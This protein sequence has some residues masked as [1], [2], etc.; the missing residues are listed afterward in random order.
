[1]IRGN[2]SSSMYVGTDSFNKWIDEIINGKWAKGKKRRVPKTKKLQYYSNGGSKSTDNEDYLAG[3]SWFTEGE[4]SKTPKTSEGEEPPK[5]PVMAYSAIINKALEAL[6]EI[7]PDITEEIESHFPP[8]SERDDNIEVKKAIAEALNLTPGNVGLVVQQSGK[9][10]IFR[11]KVPFTESVQISSVIL[12][13]KDTAGTYNFEITV[14]DI[15]YKASLDSDFNLV[16]TP[17]ETVS[18]TPLKAVAQPIVK[19]IPDN[20]ETWKNL[21]KKIPAQQTRIPFVAQFNAFLK[22]GD[23]EGANVVLEE[24]SER[25]KKAFSRVSIE[26]QD[27]GES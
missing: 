27:L 20:L 2:L 15:V 9:S 3:H 10:Y 5:D 1:M 16:L 26:L 11:G 22:A 17:P 14:G 21:M 8:K 12:T 6:A 13:N 18:E 25:F 7:D 19:V 24:N 4:Q 23:I